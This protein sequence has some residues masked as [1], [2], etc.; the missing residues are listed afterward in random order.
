M[1][2]SIVNSIYCFQSFFFYLYRAGPVWLEGTSDPVKK[3]IRNVTGRPRSWGVVRS[4]SLSAAPGILAYA[5][6]LTL[7]PSLSVG[8]PPHTEL[9]T[10]TSPGL[11]DLTDMA[12]PL[13]DQVRSFSSVSRE[14]LI[15]SLTVTCHL[16][17][18]PFP[19]GVGRG[20]AEELQQG[21]GEASKV[22]QVTALLSLLEKEHHFAFSLYTGMSGGHI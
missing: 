1:N 11:L 2:L 15:G 8:L 7:L 21:L 10:V 3:W 18:S 9:P 20:W 5:P 19:F 6:F 13:S 16:S 17:W 22:T 14:A 12:S 4:H